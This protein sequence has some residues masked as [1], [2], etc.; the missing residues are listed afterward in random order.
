MPLASSLSH[1]VLGLRTGDRCRARAAQ[2]PRVVRPPYGRPATRCLA[3][4]QWWATPFPGNHIVAR[5]AVSRWR[6]STTGIDGQARQYFG[7]L[8]RLCPSSP[9]RPPPSCWPGAIRFLALAEGSIRSG[10]DNLPPNLDEA[11]RTL[12]RTPFA[13]CAFPCAAA[14]PD[15]PEILAAMILV[16][17]SITV[18]ELVQ[19]R[20]C[21]GPFGFNPLATVRSK[22]PRAGLLEGRRPLRRC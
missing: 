2:R 15:V 12:G 7:L 13:R 17:P 6:R 16:L 4:C 1:R 5:P 8:D 14:T 11:A 20:C 19:Q 10:L 3:R 22:T 21:C 9:A 18:K